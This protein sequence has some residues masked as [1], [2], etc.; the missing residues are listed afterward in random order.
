MN[1]NI[2][3]SLLFIIFFIV[4]FNDNSY[5]EQKEMGNYIKKSGEK[6][7]V[8]SNRVNVREKA[9]ISS[10]VIAKLGITSIVKMLGINKELITIGSIKGHW[11]YVKTPYL[12]DKTN[13]R[14]KGWVFDYYLADL[15]QF[16]ALNRFKQCL[17]EG[18]VG[19]YLFSYEFYEDG[20]FR[21][22]EYKENSNE[23][24]YVKGKMFKYR[25]VIIALDTEEKY[26]MRALFYIDDKDNLYSPFINT[27]TEKPFKC[28]S[29]R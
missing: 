1:K 16:K 19:D 7:Y 25:N 12:D 24:K 28:V 15:N 29:F 21:R 5:S 10:N 14:L 27:E 18:W 3:L 23:L 8:V 13:K 2:L 11:A 17:I 4:I 26:K 22:K 20:S 6:R 9:D